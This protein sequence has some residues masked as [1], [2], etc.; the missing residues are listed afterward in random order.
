MNWTKHIDHNSS[1]DKVTSGIPPEIVSIL[2]LHATHISLDECNAAI[3]VVLQSAIEFKL[4][5]LFYFNSRSTF[6]STFVQFTRNQYLQ[7]H[8][9]G[10]T[11]DVEQFI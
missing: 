4:Q 9:D 1:Y 7:H 2:H 5:F 11:K 3:E 8:Q 10:S 6:T